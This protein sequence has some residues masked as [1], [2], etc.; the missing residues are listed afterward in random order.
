[1]ANE[2]ISAGANGDFNLPRENKA[3]SGKTKGFDP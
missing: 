3:F 1:M 2:N